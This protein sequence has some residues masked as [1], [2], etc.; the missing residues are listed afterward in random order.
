MF[1]FFFK[2]FCFGSEMVGN[3][4]VALN[5]EIGESA[6]VEH[7]ELQNACIVCVCVCLCLHVTISFIFWEFLRLNNV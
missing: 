2:F 5:A 6:L 3:V 7:D 4:S 1:F